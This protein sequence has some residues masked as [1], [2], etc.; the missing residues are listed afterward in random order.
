MLLQ[1]EPAK[2]PQQVLGD[3][4][5]NSCPALSSHQLAQTSTPISIIS[6][7]FNLLGR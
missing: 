1:H 7:R 6:K 4:L 5:E 3:G 2:V